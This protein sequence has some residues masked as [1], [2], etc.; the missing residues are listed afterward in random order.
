VSSVVVGGDVQLVLDEGIGFDATVTRPGGSLFRDT[1]TRLLPSLGYQ[2]GLSGRPAEGDR[3][4]VGFNGA[5]TSDNRNGLALGRLQ[6]AAVVGG[7]VATLADSYGEVVQV[8]GS[9]TGSARLDHNAAEGLLQQSTELRNAYSGV[10]LDE[11]AAALLRFEQAYT[12]SARVISTARTL[13]DSLLSIF[14]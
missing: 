6:S 1:P 10:D 14:N 4:L 8:V 9:K 11:E 7:G 2:V 13:F 12:A 5:G 3:F